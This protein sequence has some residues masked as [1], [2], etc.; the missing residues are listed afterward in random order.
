MEAWELIEQWAVSN[1]AVQ[2]ESNLVRL[3]GTVS[4]EARVLARRLLWVPP[5]IF[6]LESESAGVRSIMRGCLAARMGKDW[7]AELAWTQIASEREALASALLSLGEV[8]RMAHD[9]KAWALGKQDWSSGR[10]GDPAGSPW[11][12]IGDALHRGL[13]DERARRA[14]RAAMER[15]DPEDEDGDA[16]CRMRWSQWE[17]ESLSCIA[18]GEKKDESGSKRI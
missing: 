12:I 2:T 18:S 11:R 13:G 15:L 16:W 4:G 5:A 1:E 8:A 6:G 9:G 14:M 10:A 7:G 17:K 3:A